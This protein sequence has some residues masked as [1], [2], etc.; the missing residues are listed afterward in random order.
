MV[1]DISI[2]VRFSITVKSH[3]SL[4]VDGFRLY[5]S[6]FPKWG[7]LV[8]GGWG[9][10]GGCGNLGKMT[11]NCMKITNSA[12]LGENSGGEGDKP[13][14]RVVGGDPPSPPH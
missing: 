2:N 10:G 7:R 11:K 14:F 5:I 8:V 12:F 4:S 6:G 3:F 9:G 13:I 1:F